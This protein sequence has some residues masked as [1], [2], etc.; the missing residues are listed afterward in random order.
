MLAAIALALALGAEPV[1]AETG[2]SAS[3]PA[4][5][6]V[7]EPKPAYGPPA[8]KKAKRKLAS[9][10]SD[11]A[12]RCADARQTID[13][14]TTILVCGQTNDEYRLDPDIMRAEEA[15]K[16]ARRG[17][18]PPQPM[19]GA[20]PDTGICER[21]GGCRALEAINWVGVA[22]VAAQ[23]ANKIS[24]GENPAEILV[25]NPQTNEYE[26]YRQSKAYRE[27]KTEEED[28]DAAAKRARDAK[29]AKEKA[30]ADTTLVTPPAAQDQ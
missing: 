18:A 13:D 24:K 16:A 9:A 28:A 11:T 3:A 25:T 14:K 4:T 17:A 19:P 21:S 10:P 27:A 12:K 20:M 15:R 2:E 22:M 23:V 8:P 26:Y 6:P 1:P 29:A 5:V 30:D 7:E